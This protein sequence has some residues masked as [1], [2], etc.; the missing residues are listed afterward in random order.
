VQLLERETQLALLKRAYRQVQE[1]T[2]GACVLL[3]GEAG[4]GKTSLLREFLAGLDGAADLLVCGCEALFT[5][6][7]LGPLVDLADRFPPSVS[8]ALHQG[9]IHNG[10]FPALLS[11]LRRDKTPAVLA[12]EDVHWADAGTLDYVRYLGRRLHEARTLLVLTYRSDEV[13]AEHPL[14]RAVGD[15]PSATT[16]RI[17][18][19]ALSASAVAEMAARAQHSARGLYEATGGN[20][21]YVGELLQQQDGGGV[22]L[23]VA[24][25]VLARLARLPAAARELCELVSMCP[26]RADH[27]VLYAVMGSVVDE[28]DRCLQLGLLVPQGD[29]LSFRHELVRLAVHES[30]AAQRRS[31][32]HA[33]V[34]HAL[35]E[36]P[37]QA[38]ELARQVH[39]AEGAGLVDE[40]ARLAPRAALQAAATG[41][42]REA[43]RLYALAVQ[44]GEPMSALQRAELLEAHANESLLSNQHPQAL[45]SRRAALGLRRALGDTLGEGA[46]LRWQARLTW[47]T[48]GDKAS[49]RALAHQ[50]IEVLESMPP[51]PER[52][53]AYGTLSHLCL[54]SGDLPAT[55]RWG[56]QAIELARSLRDA[57]SLS[58]ALLNVAAARL[59]LRDEPAA[60]AMLHQSLDLAL[61]HGLHADAARAYFGAFLAHA[62]H[63][64][65]AQGLRQAEQGIAYSETHGVE[66]LGVRIRVRRAHAYVLTGQWDLADA[67]TDH[68]VQQPAL[69][70]LEAAVLE[71]VRALLA[72]RRAQDGAGARLLAAADALEA[73]ACEQWFTSTAA[74]RA[75]AAWLRG[76]LDAMAQALHARFD[77]MWAMGDAWRA[78][79]LAVWMRRGGGAAPG[80][81]APARLPRPYALELAGDTRAAAAEWQRLG[82]PYEAA[83]ALSGGDEA[84]LADALAAFEALGAA[85]AA[86]TVRRRLRVLGVRGLSVL[87]RGPSPRTRADPL[88]LTTREREVFDLLLRGL[89]NAAIAQ[90]LH[91]SERTVEHHVAAVFGKTDVNSRAELL[92][93]YAAAGAADTPFAK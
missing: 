4:I 49:T 17:A 57:E 3:F 71:F 38:G 48:G 60:W 53:A 14:R 35:Q 82:C 36:L 74:A 62:V 79:E 50:A 92:A 90:R 40:V 88:G 23:S 29:G 41:A 73:M 7:P 72:M 78:G 44:C 13:D 6:R 11:F 31:A 9:H 27:T 46:N 93:A 8:H 2:A 1:G 63:R 55:E 22:P 45:A 58:Y 42:H 61:T 15:L 34:F 64:D 91:R 52:A 67:D 43:A 75:E 56:A 33:A 83:L 16:T 30:I 19:P 47:L 21:F 28:A 81:Q 68:L 87:R 84:A 85:A 24:D 10:L 66:V 86:E 76:D 89:S 51:H 5:P 25:S 77:H 39:H 59:R 32:L 65:F 18:L 80:A 37:A 26:A 20:P 54:V 70:V 12:I 69:P